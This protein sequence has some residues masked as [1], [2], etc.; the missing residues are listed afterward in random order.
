M[1]YEPNNNV[2]YNCRYHVVWCSK[3]RRPVLTGEVEQRL[4]ELIHGIAADI[5]VDIIEMEIKPDFVHLLI[6][7]H[8]Q[9][10]VHRAVKAIK[11][12]TSSVL[13]KEFPVLSSRIPTLWT[14][15]Y[16]LATV[17]NAPTDDIQR[18]VADQK[19]A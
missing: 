6:S 11:G 19:N 7:V 10:G 13:R 8:P 1:S 16:F 4:K 3:Y 9:F 2:S 17:G 5:H 12:R 18:F 14:N 15:R